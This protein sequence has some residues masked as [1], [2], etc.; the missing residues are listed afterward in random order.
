MEDVTGCSLDRAVTELRSGALLAY[1]TETLFGLGADGRST[2]AV[3]RLLQWKGRQPGQPLPILVEDSE[4]L[5]HLGVELSPLPRRLADAFWPGPLTLV[6]YCPESFPPGVARRDGAVGFRCS[7]HPAAAAL[8]RRVAREGIGPLTA[9]SLNRSGE[10]PA[11]TRSE[12]ARYCDG[13]P[14][15]PI[16]M[17]LPDAEVGSGTPSSV[18]DLTGPEPRMLREGSISS[19]EINA[20]LEDVLKEVGSE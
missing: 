12:A 9:T 14:G 18:L 6:L 4:A 16:L 11:R 13:R 15:S 19:A 7:S 17:D 10:T 1:P 5:A 20:V 8:A 3:E 2:T